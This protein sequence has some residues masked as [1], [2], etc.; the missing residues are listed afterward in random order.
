MTLGCSIQTILNQQLMTQTWRPRTQVR[1]RSNVRKTPSTYQ[2]PG[3]RVSF[4]TQLETLT[5]TRVTR[6]RWPHEA[7]GVRFGELTS[8]LTIRMDVSRSS[9]WVRQNSRALTI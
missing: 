7:P 2:A 6:Q 9:Y 4:S 5:Q 8:I 3:S 1:R